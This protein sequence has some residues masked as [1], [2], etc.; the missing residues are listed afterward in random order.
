VADGDHVERQVAAAEYIGLIYHGR[1]IT[2]LDALSH[3]M[4]NGRLF[5]GVPAA[6]VTTEHGATSHSVLV[7]REGIV[8]RGI[9]VDAPRHRGVDWLDSWTPVQRDEVE[10]IVES[11]GLEIRA[12]DALLLRTGY[13]RCRIEEGPRFDG[14]QSG[15]GASCLPLFHDKGVA[16]IAADTS[17]ETYPSG[18]KGF[19]GPIHGIGIAAMG[20]W[21]LDNCNL[22][23]LAATCDELA[24]HEFALILAP[25]PFVGATGSPINPLALF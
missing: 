17:Q 1:R 15:W 14:T 13:G 19:R 7:A 24:T 2:H 18:F 10:A 3:V 6:R 8:T 22:E 11:Y 20:L 5:N 4:W 9:L 12:G 25:I 16:V 21:L 23:P